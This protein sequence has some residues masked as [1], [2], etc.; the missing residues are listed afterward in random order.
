MS[1]YI[2]AYG[3]Y[4]MKNL[5]KWSQALDLAHDIKV[6]GPLRH[7]LS[8]DGYASSSLNKAVFNQFEHA[9]IAAKP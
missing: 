1:N 5:K 4:L 8:I 2:W 7:G 9:P 6:P 3:K